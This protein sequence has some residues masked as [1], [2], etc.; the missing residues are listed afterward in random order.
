M[1]YDGFLSDT[2]DDAV[3]SYKTFFQFYL[4]CKNEAGLTKFT[5]FAAWVE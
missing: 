1:C 2:A 5:S 4:I 3:D